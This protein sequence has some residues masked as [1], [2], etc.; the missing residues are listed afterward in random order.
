MVEIQLK[1]GE[2]ITVKNYN[3]ALLKCRDLHDAG[4]PVSD[5]KI[6]DNTGNEAPVLI[7]HFYI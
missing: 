5:M 1:N 2:V 3:D 6:I 7:R 4:T